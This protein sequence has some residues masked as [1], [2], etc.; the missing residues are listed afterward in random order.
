MSVQ[1]L[2]LPVFNYIRAAIEK[3]AYNR[4]V[5]QFY[6]YSVAVHFKEKDIQKETERLIKSWCNLNELSY[7]KKYEK[8]GEQFENLANF[9]EI[10]FTHK[11]LN[12]I[13]FIKYVQC[14]TYNIEPEHF[15]LTEQ[16]NKDLQLLKKIE[17]E[18]MAAYINSLEEY[19]NANW[20]D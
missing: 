2:D 5:D 19:K 4:T 1:M 18:A 11:P 15:T 3:A 9:I 12:I 13:Q 10:T 7:C 8:H 6:F 20:S 14:L 16:Q 17:V